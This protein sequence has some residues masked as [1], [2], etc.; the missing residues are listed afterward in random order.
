M[1]ANLSKASAISD[2]LLNHFEFDD[3]LEMS[4]VYDKSFIAFCLSPQINYKTLDFN[5]DISK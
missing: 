3:S 4:V 2:I 5:L 1:Y